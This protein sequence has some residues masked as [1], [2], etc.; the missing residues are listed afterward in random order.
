[1]HSNLFTVIKKAWLIHPLPLKFRLRWHFVASV[2]EVTFAHHVLCKFID[3]VKNSTHRTV[4]YTLQLRHMCNVDIHVILYSYFKHFDWIGFIGF[5]LGH[6]VEEYVLICFTQNIFMVQSMIVTIKTVLCLGFYYELDHIYYPRED[7]KLYFKPI[8]LRDI[9]PHLACQHFEAETIGRHIADDIFK[10]IFWNETS[11]KWNMFH[12]VQ[13]GIIGS[14]NGL[15]PD[16]RKQLF[17]P[18]MA[19]FTDA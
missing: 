13:Q 11:F 2:M 18:R 10:C 19:R 3:Y 12:G 5:M 8:K 9:E 6:A 1:M 4:A 7:L 16:W 17:G 15:P 14:D